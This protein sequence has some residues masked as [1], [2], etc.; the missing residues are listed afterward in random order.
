MTNKELIEQH[1]GSGSAEEMLAELK[2]MQKVSNIN[3]FVPAYMGIGVQFACQ[4][5]KED[6]I[7]TLASAIKEGFGMAAIYYYQFLSGG[8]K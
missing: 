8:T 5:K 4:L 6:P 3:L 7:R 1:F 2:E